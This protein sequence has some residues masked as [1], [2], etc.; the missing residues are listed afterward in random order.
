MPTT[1][2]LFWALPPPSTETVRPLGKT[3]GSRSSTRMFKAHSVRAWHPGQL[4][5][6]AQRQVIAVPFH[7]QAPELPRPPPL[8]GNH[9][10]QR[11]G[12]NSG[13]A[14]ADTIAATIKA[15]SLIC[16]PLSQVGYSWFE[17]EQK[18]RY[19]QNQREIKL[20]ISTVSLRQKG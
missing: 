3:K 5:S 19:R 8:G 4:C 14:V 15:K 18:K 6:L 2:I 11:R 7:R 12:K 1:Q 16:M 17:T 9:N 10:A 20:R 13:T